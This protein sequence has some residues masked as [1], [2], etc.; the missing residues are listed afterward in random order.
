MCDTN[1]LW[2]RALPRDGTE[3]YPGVGQSSTPGW[4]TP[5]PHFNIEMSISVKPQTPLNPKAR[6]DPLHRV[7]TTT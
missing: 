2:D 5:S 6:P 1:D 3:L 4:D 7:I